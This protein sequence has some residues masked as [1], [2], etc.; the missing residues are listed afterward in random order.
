[1]Q[2]RHAGHVSLGEV[3]CAPALQMSMAGA[4]SRSRATRPDGAH[5]CC[6]PAAG[7]SEAVDLG[8]V[9]AG[10]STPDWRNHGNDARKQGVG[11]A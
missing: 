1:M 9:V 2:A 6:S 8:C 3:S 5:D 10:G 4:A 7:E 11:R